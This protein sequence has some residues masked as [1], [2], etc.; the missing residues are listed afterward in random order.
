MTHAKHCFGSQYCCRRKRIEVGETGKQRELPGSFHCNPGDGYV[1]L[2]N[3]GGVPMRTKKMK[4]KNTS[5]GRN[6][7]KQ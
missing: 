7:H 6:G 4:Q 2:A 1:A 5:T 3:E